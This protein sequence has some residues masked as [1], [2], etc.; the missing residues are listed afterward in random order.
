MSRAPDDDPAALRRRLHQL[1][2]PSGAEAATAAFVRERLAACGPSDILTGLGGHGL[3]AVFPGAADGP[4]VVLRAELDALPIA[5]TLAIP[6]ASRTP[7]CA[8]KCGHDGHMAILLGVAAE[9]GAHAPA[10]GRAVLLF[11]PAEETGQGA[12]AVAADPRFLALAPDWLFALHNLPGYA[13][14]EVLVREGAF[15]AGSAGLTVHL[16]G[17]TSHAAYPEQGK[18]P[19]RALA[20]LVTGLACLPIPGE[21][22]GELSLVTVVHARLGAPRFGTTPGDAEVLA[23][24]RAADQDVLGRLQSDAEALAERIAAAHGLGCRTAWSEEFPV[25]WNDAQ[26]VRVVREAAARA[27]L[28]CDEPDES[29]FRWSEDFG[30]LARLGRGAMFGLGAGRRQPP[31]HAERYDFPDALLGPGRRVLVEAVRGLL[32][33]A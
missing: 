29:P 31:L 21:A 24:L 25:T 22:L 12:A 7:G 9:L 8:H 33:R 32:G 2:E 14:G 17:A 20:E 30:I 27:G 19:D 11:Q 18:S 26:A 5:E 28:A 15:C 4:T 10:R 16:Q 6:H 1:A 13:E 3:A 23:T